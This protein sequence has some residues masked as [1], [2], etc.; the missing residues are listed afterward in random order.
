MWKRHSKVDNYWFMGGFTQQHRWH[1]RTLALQIKASL[2]GV[3][4][5]PYLG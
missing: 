4:P 5:P 1:S 3:L 2:E